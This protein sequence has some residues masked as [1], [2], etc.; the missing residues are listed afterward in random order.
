MGAIEIEEIIKG[1][2]NKNSAGFDRISNNILKLVNPHISKVLTE[3]INSSLETGI[4]PER[5]KVA[6]VIPLFKSGKEN[7]INNYRPIS[8]LPVFSKIL[9]KSVK[10][11]IMGYLENNIL[12]PEQFGFRSRMETQHAIMNFCKN[13]EERADHK[14]QSAVFVDTRRTLAVGIIDASPDG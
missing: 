1:L 2:K 9:E 3:V 12:C 4:V 10:K 13:M 11:Q 7:D 5:W 6:R 8:L 14:Y